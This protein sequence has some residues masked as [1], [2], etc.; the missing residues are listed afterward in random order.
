MGERTFIFLLLM[1]YIPVFDEFFLKA[2][3]INIVI[4][5]RISLYSS[6]TVRSLVVLF[7]IVGSI[8]VMVFRISLLRPM[9]LAVVSA[10]I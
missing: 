6:Y 4:F 7:L 9:D 2:G 10:G 1:T 3:L 5:D 8:R